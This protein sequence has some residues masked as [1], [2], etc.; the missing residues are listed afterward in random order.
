MC[1]RVHRSKGPARHNGT[2]VSRPNEL[3]SLSLKTNCFLSALSVAKSL[4]L[5]VCCV[6]CCLAFSEFPEAL[7]LSDDASNDFVVV[8]DSTAAIDC[9]PGEASAIPQEAIYLASRLSLSYDPM[10]SPQASSRAPDLLSLIS[11]RKI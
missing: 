1:H 11:L 8:N 5:V 3:R 6:V 7:S 10:P 2:R 4:V 9:E